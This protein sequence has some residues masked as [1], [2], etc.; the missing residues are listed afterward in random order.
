[1][2]D[3]V[4][5]AMRLPFASSADCTFSAGTDYQA[6]GSKCPQAPCA[7]LGGQG[8]AKGYDSTDQQ[9][10]CDLCEAYDGDGAPCHFG[11]FNSQ[12]KKCYLK[13]ASAA[14]K[15]GRAINHG[16][17]LTK[18]AGGG[19]VLSAGGSLGLLP[20]VG[21]L[22]LL[23]LLYCVAGVTMGKRRDGG[24]L[25]ARH[26]HYKAWAS[27]GG[28]VWDGVHFARGGGGGGGSRAVAAEAHT[29]MAV[30]ERFQTAAVE[31]LVRERSPRKKQSGKNR[32][33]SRTLP[34]PKAAAADAVSGSGTTASRRQRPTAADEEAEASAAA[35]AA[36]SAPP[37]PPLAPVREWQP[38]RTGF[39]AVGARETGVKQQL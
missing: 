8:S 35:A 21:V 5:A 28:L 37:P 14:R 20:L 39:L 12:D 23:A 4:A 33:S 26:P 1:M 16:C 31:P 27:V 24:G 2:G 34:P 15:T 9:A 17:E 32:K 36:V 13:D 22:C 11:V 3:A 38:T 10:C 6:S 25:L 7:D 29:N 18:Y 30:P 19:G